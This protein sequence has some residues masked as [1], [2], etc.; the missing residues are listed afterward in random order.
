[1]LYLAVYS[2]VHPDGFLKK[3]DILVG[4]DMEG[5]EVEGPGPS[6]SQS[7]LDYKDEED[8]GSQLDRRSEDD[9]DGRSSTASCPPSLAPSW[10][11]HTSLGQFGQSMR[12]LFFNFAS[13]FSLFFQKRFGES[14]HWQKSR[15]KLTV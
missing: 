14:F 15:R 7:I 10:D 6:P 3:E 12:L 2:M 1:M 8:H 5:G 4:E 11:S 13:T 9:K